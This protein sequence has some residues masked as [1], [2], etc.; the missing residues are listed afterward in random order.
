[1]TASTSDPD[2]GARD[3]PMLTT[4][5]AARRLGIKPE[6]LYAY[7]SRGLIDRERAP[8]GKGSLFSVADVDALADRGTRGQAG[9]PASGA[10]I[11]TAL[12]LIDPDRDRLYYR[13]R[14]AV[15]CAESTGFEAVAQWLWDG[16]RAPGANPDPRFEGHPSAVAAASAAARALPA[17]ARVTD[18]FRVAVTAAAVTDPLRFDIRPAAVTAAA[19]SLI[20]AMVMAADHISGGEDRPGAR[21]A[22]LLWPRLTRLPD[23]PEHLRALD[24]ALVLLA[25]HDMAASTYAARIAASTR[26]HPYAVVAAGLAAL[27]GPMHGGAGAL[28]HRLISDAVGSG[29]PVGVVAERLRDGSSVPGFGHL[30]YQRRDP[31]A[32]ALLRL[33]EPLPDPGGVH[34]A[35]DGL[36]A[37]AR[38]RLGSFPNVD[39]AL[40]VLAQMSGMTADA[41][42]AI[43]AVARSA[44]WIAHALE[45]YQAP[46]VRY[47]PQGLYVGPRP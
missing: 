31:R 8:D 25:D 7:V 44:G 2:S 6:T 23:T 33:I 28:A 14:D 5:Q 45:E 19:G 35:V 11:R 47:R 42:E 12:T 39:F 15:A 4:Q 30:I 18:R 27:D 24:A 21:T 17:A 1:M 29:D 37:V 26:A 13:G 41:E 9:A 34:A 40:A 20:T 10:S 38:E 43:F 16:Q 22:E 3:R 46:A 32:E 36:L